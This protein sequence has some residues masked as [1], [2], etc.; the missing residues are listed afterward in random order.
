ML[1]AALSPLLAPAGHLLVE[2]IPGAIL[3]AVPSVGSGTQPPGT[4]GIV[5]AMGYAAW[6]VCAICVVGVFICAGRMA[7]SH[8]QGMAGEHVSGIAYVLAACILVASASAIVG[9][10]V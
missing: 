8:R 4:Q 10:L 6:V 3:A 1:H 5:T 2:G 9:A 7:V